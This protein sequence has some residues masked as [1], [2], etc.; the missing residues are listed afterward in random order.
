MRRSKGP[1]PITDA[2]TGEIDCHYIINCPAMQELLYGNAY[3]ASR[4]VRNASHR[5]RT[6]FRITKDVCQILRVAY[7]S[8]QLPK[9]DV[10]IGRRGNHKRVP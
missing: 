2:V 6:D 7:R 5:E 8:S 3:V 10:I 4:G 1:A 9:F